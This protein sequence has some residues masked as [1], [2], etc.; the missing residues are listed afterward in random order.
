[1]ALPS[2]FTPHLITRNDDSNAWVLPSKKKTKKVVIETERVV[3]K[4][5]LRKLESIRKR[6]EQKKENQEHYKTLQYIS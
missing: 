4:E 1:M 2:N 5:E 6:K 3:S